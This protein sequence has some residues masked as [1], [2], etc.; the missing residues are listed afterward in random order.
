M[1]ALEILVYFFVVGI[2]MARS[3]AECGMLMTETSFRP[4]DIYQ[5]FAAKHTLGGSNLTVLGFLDAGFLRD[6]RGLIL[7]GF[8]DGLRVGDGVN[9][10]RRAFLPV[11]GIAIV[12]AMGVAG[13]L[14]LWFPYHHGAI[15]LYTYPY[16]GNSLWAFQNHAPAMDN[17]LNYDWRAPTFAFIGMVVTLFLVV[18]RASFPWFPLHPM[19]YA[20]CGSWTL[21][22]FWFPCLVAWVLKSLVS[23][24][25][26]MK[27]YL[28]IRP[29]FLGLIL[30]EFSM[31][32][33]WTLMAA[34]LG[35]TAPAFPW[36]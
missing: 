23:R 21:I 12:L 30:G 15:Q 13:F 3:V 29:F 7:T 19:G 5:I 14:H 24:Y 16:Q 9:I 20:L 26:G 25:G 35:I 28:L 34:G 22:V 32:V 2:V 6:Q 18:M 8:L 4:I 33:F 36:P 10:R 1:A 27:Y 17:V 31:A 11:F